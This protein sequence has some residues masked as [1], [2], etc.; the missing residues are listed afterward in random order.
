MSVGVWS[1]GNLLLGGECMKM[2]YIY[3][4]IDSPL[5]IADNDGNEYTIFESE[6][7]DV[8]SITTCGEY[9]KCIVDKF[10]ICD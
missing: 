3:E 6:H 5:I 4:T 1:S 10:T 2:G 9:I 7:M 8:I